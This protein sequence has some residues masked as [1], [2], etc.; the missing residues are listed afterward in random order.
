MLRVP[1]LDGCILPDCRGHTTLVRPHQSC[2][3]Y[4]QNHAGQHPCIEGGGHSQPPR[5]FFQAGIAAHCVLDFSPLR[6]QMVV[7]GGIPKIIIR[8]LKSTDEDNAIVCFASESINRQGGAI[9][10]T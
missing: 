8:D 10:K 6:G 7:L 9:G 3:P 1:G 4:P 2:K 5:H